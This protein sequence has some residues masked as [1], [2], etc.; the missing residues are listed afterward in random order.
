MNITSQAEA[1]SSTPAVCNVGSDSSAQPLGGLQNAPQGQF[2]YPVNWFQGVRP[3]TSLPP[4]SGLGP[5]PTLSQHVN[6]TMLPSNP[7]NMPSLLGQLPTSTSYIPSPTNHAGFTA[8]P[9]SSQMSALQPLSAQPNVVSY[10]G[11][12]GPMAVRA[13]TSVLSQTSA[14]LL[15]RPIHN[16]QLTPLGSSGWARAH[17][18]P[19]IASSQGS[20]HMGQYPSSAGNMVSSRPFLSQPPIQH[21]SSLAMNYP[22]STTPYGSMPVQPGLPAAPSTPILSSALQHQHSGISS[23]MSGNSMSCGPP[24]LPPNTTGNFTFQPHLIPTP[25]PQRVTCQLGPHNPPPTQASISQPSAF[26]PAVLNSAPPVMHGTRP[27]VR[28]MVQPQFQVEAVRRFGNHA[29]EFISPRTP[30]DPNAG[31][32]AAR[33]SVP[34]M[35]PRNFGPAPQMPN[36]AGAFTPRPPNPHQQNFRA[37][38]TRPENLHS[39]NQQFGMKPSPQGQIYDPFSPTSVAAQQQGSGMGNTRRQET[40]PEYED[41]MASVGVK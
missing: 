11:G 14:S 6:T 17:T 29:S 19:P 5:P 26:R 1:A 2:Q 38:N 4:S 3:Q 18:G 25:G 35:G 34:H 31:I 28:Q 16:Q 20:Q 13:S 39:A 33:A 40:D 24:R 10:A 23:S 7:S 15:P 41:L 21:V 37:F 12:Q 22:T 27:Q 30:T 8:P 32:V 36:L 9:S